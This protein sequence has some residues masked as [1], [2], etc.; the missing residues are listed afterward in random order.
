MGRRTPSEDAIA[1]ANPRPYAAPYYDPDLPGWTAEQ[2]STALRE[3]YDSICFW[4]MAFKVTAEIPRRLGGDA[5]A[6]QLALDKKGARRLHSLYCKMDEYWR[7][8]TSELA[9]LPDAPGAEHRKRGAQVDIPTWV[10]DRMVEVAALRIKVTTSLV[11]LDEHKTANVIV[12]RL[13][14]ELIGLVTVAALYPPGVA[15]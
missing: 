14:Q 7:K 9:G 1:T 13:S 8:T 3:H 11:R 6:D 5:T 15:N 4:A 10:Q 2:V 12:N